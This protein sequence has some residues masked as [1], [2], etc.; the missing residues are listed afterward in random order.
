MVTTMGALDTFAILLWTSARGC[1]ATGAAFPGSAWPC[2]RESG[3]VEAD[4]G[5]GFDVERA[6]GVEVDSGT[7]FAV[8]VGGCAETDAG[9]GLELDGRGGVRC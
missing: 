6:D 3:G 1:P 4:A 7:A 9:D 8:E 2:C 5:A